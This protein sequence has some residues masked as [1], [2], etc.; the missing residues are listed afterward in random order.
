MNE[1]DKNEFAITNLKTFCKGV[2]DEATRCLSVTNVKDS[3][4]DDFIT[5]K[6]CI[7]I[8]SDVCGHNKNLK[9]VVRD[10]KLIINE[11]NYVDIVLIV[12]E[13]IYQ[14]ALCKLAAEDIIQCAWDTDVNRMVFWMEDDTGEK[15]ELEDT[16]L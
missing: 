12:A 7:D 9:K 10:Y 8:V 4:I 5:I 3:N 1:E 13:Q 11:D 16:I 6:Q 15:R 14:S 2:R